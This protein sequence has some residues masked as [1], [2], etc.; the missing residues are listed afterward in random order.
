M[1]IIRHCFFS[2]CEWLRTLILVG[3]GQNYLPT[4]FYN[5]QSLKKHEVLLA[6]L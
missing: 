5:I 1:I 2:C 6:R 3:T 4:A